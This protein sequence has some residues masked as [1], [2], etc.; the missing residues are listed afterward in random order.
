MKSGFLHSTPSHQKENHVHQM[1]H[2]EH[3]MH[4]VNL[5][6]SRCEKSFFTN[7]Q[8]KYSINKKIFQQIKK[9]KPKLDTYN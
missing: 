2:D 3:M 1:S 4:M 5:L 9:V 7:Y 6:R 8:N